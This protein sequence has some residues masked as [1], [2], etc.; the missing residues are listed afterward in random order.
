MQKAHSYFLRAELGESGMES[1]FIFRSYRAEQ[2][3]PA[4]GQGDDFL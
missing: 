1:R 3:I 4:I 2:E